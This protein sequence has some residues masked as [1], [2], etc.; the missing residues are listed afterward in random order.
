MPETPKN[1]K[2]TLS[3][4]DNL[5]MALKY[6]MCTAGAGI[7]QFVSF[8]LL[9]AAAHFDRLPVFLKLFPG[10]AVTELKYGP[11]YFVALALS[12]IFNFTANR[13]YTFRSANNVPIAMAKVLGYY[14]VFT[15]L[16]IWWGEA[17]AQHGWNEF[18]ILVPTML[19]NAVTEFLF[20]R[21]V[22]FRDSINTAVKGLMNAAKGN[23]HVLV[24][25]GVF[26]LL[27]MLVMSAFSSCSILFSGT[28]QVSGQTIY[29][30]EDRDIRGAETD[31]KK[32]EKELEKRIKRTPTDHP[33]YN[34]YQYHLDP[35]EH[36]P[37]Q[38]TSFLTTLYDNYTRSEVQGKLKE[39]FKKQ[40]KLTTWVEVQIRY[41][42]VWVISPAGIPV[43]TQVPYEYKIFHTKLV[44][45]GL[46]VVIREEL[47]NDQWKRYEIFQ[48]T[49]G[50][51]PYLFNGGLPPGGSDGSGT[52]GIDY[53][54]P[55]EALT[56]SEFA[57]IYKEAQKYVGTPYVWGGSTPET[58]FDCSGYVCWVYNQNGYDVGRT[59]ANGLWNKSQH[60][61]EADAKPGD[62]VFFKGTYD[63]PG[64]SHTGI[65][66]GNGMM[67]SAGDPIKYANIHSSYWEKHL[68]GFGRLSK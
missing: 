38:L 39:T 5:L 47:D 42:T 31:Y 55:A 58:G 59:T 60:I 26:L 28:T 10:A 17:L 9:N 30:A 27:L 48:D 24:I 66:L 14:L 44:N 46:E 32:L 45:R 19:V 35:I 15:P 53:Q 63:T 23:A 18:A 20:N 33:G 16:S 8:T 49:L 4:R 22:V 56:D 34:E 3:K 29:T 12:V 54:V 43:P 62:L 67:V 41:K 52:P 7:I 50:G 68:A 11:S 6:L 65:Y 13:K 36:D 25:V 61:S 64:M 37:W 40:Y 21:F 51:R 1:E 57:A 2:P